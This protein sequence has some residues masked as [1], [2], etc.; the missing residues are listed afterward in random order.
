MISLSVRGVEQLHKFF[1]EL[2]PA[3]RKIL[4]PPI[5]EYLIGDESHGLKHLVRY[6]Y[7]SR[8]AAYPNISFR[9]KAGNTIVGY[10]NL[11]QFQAV[12]AG[13][14]NGSINPGQDNRTG[15]TQA[16]WAYKLQGGGYGAS[17]YNST[18]GAYYVQG[19]SSQARQPAMVGHRKVSD[20]ISTN[21]KGAIR[22]A[23]Q[24]FSRWV[25]SH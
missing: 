8:K 4:I 16:G 2:S 3:L 23:E 20:V 6:K 11:A 10:K 13:M 22:A 12:H 25:K 21:I 17:I 15:A 19:D 24:A 18:K 5:A 1:A 9:T 14:R 7:V